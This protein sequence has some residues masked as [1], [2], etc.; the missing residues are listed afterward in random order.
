M[1]T[2]D[3]LSLHI[4]KGDEF[5]LVSRVLAYKFNHELL[6]MNEEKGALAFDNRYDRQ[7]NL[8]EQIS[9]GPAGTELDR[10]RLEYNDAGLISKK[11]TYFRR[12]IDHYRLEYKYEFF[13]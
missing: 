13:D 3:L 5:P 9:Y 12:G 1:E 7:G 2:S 10:L 8:L 4:P 6:R 11:E